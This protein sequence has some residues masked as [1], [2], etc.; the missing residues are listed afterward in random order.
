VTTD[1]KWSSLR[2]LPIKR[3]CWNNSLGLTWL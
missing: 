2:F 1:I 3:V